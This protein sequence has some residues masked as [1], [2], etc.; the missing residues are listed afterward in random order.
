MLPWLFHRDQMI[1][2]IL[3]EIENTDLKNGFLID[4]MAPLC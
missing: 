2:N 3:S 4:K 1:R